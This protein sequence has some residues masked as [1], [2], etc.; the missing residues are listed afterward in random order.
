MKSDR[1]G[2][3]SISVAT[4]PGCIDTAVTFGYS[5]ATYVARASRIYFDMKYAPSGGTVKNACHELTL[6]ILAGVSGL[7]N[8]RRNER[9]SR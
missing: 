9:M 5:A 8:K 4:R 1:K 6:T 2:S 7:G 3:R